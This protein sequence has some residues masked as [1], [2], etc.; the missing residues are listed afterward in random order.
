VFI[1]SRRVTGFLGR[2]PPVFL[3]T[4]RGKG[5]P[6]GR[7]FLRARGVPHVLLCGCATDMCVQATTCGH[8]N[9]AADFNV[10]EVGD[11]TLATSP[12]SQTPAL[13]TPVALCHAAPH[14]MISQA[15]WIVYGWE[16]LRRGL[17]EGE[18][19]PDREGTRNGLFAPISSSGGV[20]PSRAPILTS[21]SE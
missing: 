20:D 4:G 15:G 19:R 9:P 21:R 8:D 11:A 1:T 18:D 10:F 14:Q 2:L 12:A 6:R 3:P 7:G 16:G 5:H 17:A 13:A